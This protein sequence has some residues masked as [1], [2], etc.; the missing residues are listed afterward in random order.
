MVTVSKKTTD[1]RTDNCGQ[2]PFHETE[3]IAISV[4]AIG[5]GL[6]V[7]SQPQTRFCTAEDVASGS[8]RS[9]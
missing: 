7:P 9:C 3:K 1:K 8:D 2:F 4:R 5:R 6:V